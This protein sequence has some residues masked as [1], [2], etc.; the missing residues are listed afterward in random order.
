MYV[1][2]YL[3]AYTFFVSFFSY[4]VFSHSKGQSELVAQN[5][6]FLDVGLG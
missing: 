3:T 4:T 5:K 1:T 2:S 6:T